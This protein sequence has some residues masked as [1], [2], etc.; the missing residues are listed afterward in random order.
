MNRECIHIY[1]SILYFNPFSQSC[2]LYA[3]LLLMYIPHIY[4][5]TWIYSIPSYN[6]LPIPVPFI[7]SPTDQPEKYV[8]KSVVWRNIWCVYF[9]S[10][11]CKLRHFG[12]HIKRQ[13]YKFIYASTFSFTFYFILCCTFAIR[14]KGWKWKRMNFFFFFRELRNEFGGYAG[15]ILICV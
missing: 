2:I 11:K 5:S 6:V 3:A 4:P 10:R 8:Y 1:A 12:W 7:F 9:P 15:F 13:I 14:K